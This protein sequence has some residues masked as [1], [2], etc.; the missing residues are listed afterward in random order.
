MHNMRV[1]WIAVKFKLLLVTHSIKDRLQYRLQLVKKKI[2]N[3]LY[4]TR[5]THLMGRLGNKIDP[6]S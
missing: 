4:N 5:I 2:L 6:S 1:L 3:P